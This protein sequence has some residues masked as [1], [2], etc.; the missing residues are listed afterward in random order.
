MVT[1]NMDI[2]RKRDSSKSDGAENSYM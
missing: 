1:D 2:S